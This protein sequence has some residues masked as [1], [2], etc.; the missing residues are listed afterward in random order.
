[1]L[2][3]SPAWQVVAHH[4]MLALL[5]SLTFV[6][7]AYRPLWIA[8]LFS[9]VMLMLAVAVPVVVFVAVWVLDGPYLGVRDARISHVVVTSV[10]SF[11]I[12]WAAFFCYSSFLLGRFFVRRGRLPS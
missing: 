4:A 3:A 7:A 12:I 1:M 2:E 5:L 10:S 6:M 8:D 9:R 11:V